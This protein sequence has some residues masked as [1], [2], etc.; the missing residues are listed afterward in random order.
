MPIEVGT[1]C[2][3]KKLKRPIFPSVMGERLNLGRREIRQPVITLY[4]GPSALVKVAPF[5]PQCVDSQFA[6]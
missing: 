4:F 3:G 5:T 1:T 2:V 6:P